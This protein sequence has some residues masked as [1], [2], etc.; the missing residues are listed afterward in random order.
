MRVNEPVTNE[1]IE[2]NEGQILASRTAPDSRIV[3]ANEAFTHISGFTE[4]EL[5]GEP[6]NLV[7]HPDMPKEA[8]A[9]LWATIKA[10]RAWEGLVKNRTKSGGFYWVRANVTPVTEDG[11]HKG[12]ISVRTR[13]SREDIAKAGQA[14][15]AMRAGRP[16]MALADGE[17]VPTGLGARLASLWRS[18]TGRLVLAFTVMALIMLAIGGVTLYGMN[19]SNQAL[20]SLYADRLVPSRQL[21]SIVDLMHS[22]VSLLRDA[23]DSLEDGKPDIARQS[24]RQIIV[25][26]D[27]ITALWAEYMATYLTPEEKKLADDFAAKRGIFVREGLLEGIRIVESGDHT[28]LA[29]HVRTTLLPRF[30]NAR[31]AALALIHLQ[32][33]IG[34]EMNEEAEADFNLHMTG[35]MVIF[36]VAL[37]AAV[38]FTF[39][40]LLSLRRPLRQLAGTFDAII[41]GEATETIPLTAEREFHPTIRMLRGMRARLAYAA[42]ER[43]ENERKAA[44]E[45]RAAIQA[46]A[47]TVEAQTRAAVG[48]VAEQTAVIAGEARGMNAAAERVSNNATTV[49]AAAEQA[50]ANAQ[51]VGAA[52]E[53]LSASINEIAAQVAQAGAVAQRAVEG[54]ERAQ[55][56]IQSLS[57][58]AQRIGDVVQLI[59]SI[60]AQTNLLAL[61]ATIEAARAGDAGKGFAV[62]ASEVKNLATQ[63]ARSTE[64]ISRQIT[65]IQSTTGSVVDAVGEI[66]LRIQELASVSVAVA[67]A[68]EQQASATQEIARNV[69][70]TGTAAEEVSQRIAEVSAEAQRS[71]SQ[72]ASLLGNSDAISATIDALNGNII[73]AIRTA[74][75]DADRRLQPR[76]PVDKPCVI[77]ADGGPRLEGRLCDLSRG[78]ARVEGFSTLSAGARGILRADSLGRDC[79]ARFTVNERLPDGTLRLNFLDDAV[80]AGLTAV[81]DTLESRGR[82]AA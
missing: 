12:Y 74:T 1:E 35:A 59:G 14:Y 57:D 58:S 31:E 26:R 49:A 11:E 65:E 47:S 82:A 68:V 45:R 79:E 73:G 39:W 71:G 28:A 32:E 37:A 10:G 18:I 13:A 29:L 52:S 69:A 6:H 42:R 34:K 54:G 16:T 80:S 2:V 48:Q 9:D 77:Q 70:Q 7:R 51:A 64:E 23:D 60:A 43:E 55:Q 61:N 56:R 22:N 30:N 72:A 27:R 25:N 4:Q 38:L 81:L 3:F 40:L 19:D 33:H 53:E 5:M 67:A 63:T 50:L 8:F 21:A 75:A 17:L 24:T 36:A 46:M 66:S 62:V 20:R 41:R 44:L 76:Y 78:G 15:A